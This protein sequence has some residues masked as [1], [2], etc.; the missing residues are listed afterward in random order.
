MV[1]KHFKPVLET[2]IFNK[3]STKSEQKFAATF[4][5]GLVT[6]AKHWP[7]EKHQVLWTWLGP[8]MRQALN[9]VL[10]DT[11]KYW[12]SSLSVIFGDRDPNMLFWLIEMLIDL[13]Q[14]PMDTPYN[15]SK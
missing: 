15:T 8:L 9:V 6:G 10:A 7:F 2:I 4:V 13:V 1:L 11:D 12:G 3:L 14:T 5:A